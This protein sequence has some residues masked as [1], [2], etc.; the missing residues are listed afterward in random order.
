MD[1]KPTTFRVRRIPA[2]QD[3]STL[4][5]FLNTS[6]DGLGGDHNIRVRS[7]A[8]SPI[9]RSTNPTLVATIDFAEVPE[10]LQDAEQGWTIYLKGSRKFLLFDKSFRGF[11]PLNHVQDTQHDFE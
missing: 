1:Q 2:E 5:Y 6:V 3:I 9:D 4:P 11:T 10:R 7:L 8:P